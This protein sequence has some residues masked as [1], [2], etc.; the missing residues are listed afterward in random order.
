[1]GSI[2]G[3]P[4]IEPLGGCLSSWE[5]KLFLSLYRRWCWLRWRVLISRTRQDAVQAQA[6]AA[7]LGR[8]PNVTFMALDEVL[9]QEA[10]KL[11]AQHQLRGADAVYAAVALK[12]GCT[13]IT[14]DR[15]H[16]MRLRGVVPVV[17]PSDLLRDL[18]P[19]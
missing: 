11:A 17:T 7:A 12:A 5:N 19:S 4:A 13:L 15:E 8:L 3:S 1:M 16:L 2:G 14:L 9:A 18:G 10:L 6:F